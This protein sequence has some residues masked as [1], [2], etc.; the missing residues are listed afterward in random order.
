MLT[1]NIS[2]VRGSQERPSTGPQ[3]ANFRRRGP[4]LI[5]APLRLRR[6]R[7]TSFDLRKCLSGEQLRTE[8]E[9]PRGRLEDAGAFTGVDGLLG[10]KVACV[11]RRSHVMDRH[12]H[13]TP[14]LQ[15]SLEHR[16]NTTE[17]WQER[18]MDVHA[19]ARWDVER[20]LVKSL[21]EERADEDVR[22]T[23][24]QELDSERI[25]QVARGMYGEVWRARL[26]GAI[27]RADRICNVGGT[28]KI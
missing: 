24:A 13:L 14:A 28:E 27:H 11:E 16:V 2:E 26:L 8:I 18:G 9:E 7:I 3:H 1:G 19:A 22:C 17:I 15:A 21:I 12:T 4:A 5:A 23:I 6:S 20:L 25:V 10:E